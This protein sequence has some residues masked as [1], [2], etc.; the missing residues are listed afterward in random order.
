MECGTYPI[1]GNEIYAL[2]QQ[3]TTVPAEEKKPEKHKKYL[4]IQYLVT[5]EEKYGYKIDDGS[6]P[7]VS[8]KEEKDIYFYGE[9]EN[10]NY[11]VMKPNEYC[12]FFPED[13]HRPGC[14]VNDSISVRKVVVKISED[15]LYR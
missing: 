4:D 3:L 1:R 15:S 5:G 6:D 13:I 14:S 12:I 2:V 7:V 10:E 8:A 11:L 9:L